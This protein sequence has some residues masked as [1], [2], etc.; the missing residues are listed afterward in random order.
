MKNW[1]VFFSLF[2]FLL[3]GCSL[4]ERERELDQK[5]IQLNEREQQLTLKQQMLELKEQ[6]LNEREKQLDST[7]NQLVAD[8]LIKLY[9][10]LPGDWTV[11]M[12]CIETTC[13]GSAVG[14]TKNETW[15]FRF[16]NNNIITSA[17]SNNKIVRVYNGNFSG[18]GIKL[19]IQADS[20]EVNAPKITIRLQN[21][22]KKAGEMEGER[23]IIQS[24]G[25]RILYSLELRKKSG[26]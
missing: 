11:K 9:P 19:A 10:S 15:N 22:N 5:M 21:S 17:Y 25:C 24:N 13:T 1:I 6:E 20:S 4:R 16:Q 23:E 2:I 8:S 7:S 3:P 18:N 14:D 12:V 26:G